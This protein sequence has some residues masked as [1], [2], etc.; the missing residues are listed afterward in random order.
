LPGLPAGLDARPITT[1]LT[2]F[3]RYTWLNDPDAVGRVLVDNVANYRRADVERR[4]FAALFGEG[5]LGTEGETW[6]A[7]RKIMAPAF[8]PRSVAALV[9]AMASEAE[10]FAARWAALGPGASVDV[11]DDMTRLTLR[12]IARTMFA[13]DGERFAGL[14][15]RAVDDARAALRPNVLDLLPGLSTLRL[16]ALERRMRAVFAEVDAALGQLI[17]EREAAAAG[18]ATNDLLSRLIAAKDGDTGRRMTAQEVRDQV[19]TIFIAGHETTAAAMTWI[20]FLLAQHPAEAATLRAELAQ[21]LAGR[22]PGP[23]DIAR[24]PYT[25]AVVDEALRLYPPA[26]GLAAREATAA[27]QLGDVRIP[28]RRIVLVLPWLLHRNPAVWPD[29]E[30]FDPGR[31][32]GPA[33]GRRR[34]AYFPF[35]AGPRVCIGFQL[36][37]TE[38]V[39]VLATLAQRFAPTLA[40]DTPVELER[41]VTLRPKGGLPMRLEPAPD[42]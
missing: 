3:G 30:R 11:S 8:D 26:P 4:I 13:V 9:P 25:R 39:T 1:R 29:P 33:A 12:I 31:F 19:V 40:S 23:D 37:L 15:S 7:H 10:A 42:R 17:D 14:V 21:V 27:D 38:L 34:G 24:L 5:L 36:A 35:G 16:R 20:W 6:R 32:L 28:A 41:T 22:A 2:L 18:P